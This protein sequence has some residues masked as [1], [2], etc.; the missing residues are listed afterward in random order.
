MPN[1]TRGKK[2]RERERVY[3]I[4][5]GRATNVNTRVANV[6]IVANYKAVLFYILDI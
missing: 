2:T 6:Y 5:K 4:E 1:I 3:E